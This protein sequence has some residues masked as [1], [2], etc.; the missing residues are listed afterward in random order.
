MADTWLRQIAPYGE[1]GTQWGRYSPVT[2]TR[3]D[4]STNRAQELSAIMANNM[5]AR[6]EYQSQID[7]LMGLRE[8]FTGDIDWITRWLID[9]EIK[10]L[11]NQKSSCNSTAAIAAYNLENLHEYA[12]GSPTMSPEEEEAYMGK[13]EMWERALDGGPS[14]ETFPDETFPEL[15]RPP[16]EGL[17]LP[18]WLQEYLEPSMPAGVEG[19]RKQAYALRPLG[20]QADLSLEQMGQM[21]GYLGWTKAGAPT[22][23]SQWLGPGPEKSY[24]G[25]RYLEKREKFLPWWQEYQRKAQAMF[26]SEAR[27]PKITWRPYK[28]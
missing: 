16:T 24:A 4:V 1:A 26:P 9:Q 7:T 18:E 25:E 8:Q 13:Y 23:W 15:N 6:N 12:L 17:P 2:G 3:R 19:A 5:Q 27:M 22:R 21:A 20:A 14:E 11:Q 28:E 10:S